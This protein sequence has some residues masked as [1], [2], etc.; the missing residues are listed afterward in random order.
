MTRIADISEKIARV[1]VETFRKIENS[2]VSGY[3]MVENGVCSGFAKVTDKC[4]ERMFARTGESVED[5][6]AH[7]SG[8]K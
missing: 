7:L 8:K 2:V 5:A 6:K 1:A 3:K 4:V